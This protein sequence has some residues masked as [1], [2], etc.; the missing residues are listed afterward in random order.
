MYIEGVF[1]QPFDAKSTL[2]CVSD[3]RFTVWTPK[4]VA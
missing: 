4:L 1:Q 3:G 2:L